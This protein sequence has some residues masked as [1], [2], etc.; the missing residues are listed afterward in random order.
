LKASVFP[1]SWPIARRLTVL[2]AL[3]LF[4]LLAVSAA[5]LDW[6][7]TTD[8]RRDN[9]QFLAAEM[10]NLRTLIRQRP[11]HVPALQ[12]EVEREAQSL[13]GHARFYAR[14]LN[15][16]GQI[17]V[18]TPGMGDVIE[19]KTFP[20]P[21]R[22]FDSRSVE[23]SDARGRDGRLFLLGAQWVELRQPGAGKRLIQVAFDRSHDEA[24]ISDYRKEIVVVLLVGFALSVGLGLAIARAGLKPI[25]SITRA[26]RRISADELNTRVSSREWPPE[27]AA[28]AAEFDAMLERLQNS[29][30]LLTQFSADLAHELRTPINNLRGEAEVAL[31]KTRNTEE[32]QSLLGSSLEEY[33]RLSRVIDNLLFLA[34]TDARHTAIRRTSVN[35]RK[36]ID[37]LLEYFE[38]LA[39]DKEID[40]SVTGNAL[41]NVDSALF[42]RVLVNLL[43]NAF[44]YTPQNGKIALSIHPVHGGI[45]VVVADTGIGIEK[46]HVRRVLDRFFRT[47]RARAIHPQGNGLGLPIVKSIMDLHSGHLSIE[48][49]P[50]TG[51]TVRLT[52][53]QA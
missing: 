7:L 8:M 1:P 18:E 3:S 35:V 15:E 4:L 44:Q 48:S 21:L 49:T 25:S 23:G 53:P 36:E 45:E 39:Q 13:P 34:R 11:A 43:S 50:G 10:Q 31:E 17:I 40:L 28:L 29:F 33:E 41:L 6:V 32:Y 47:E 9:S 16:Q 46:D 20:E 30:D 2:Y 14:I 22:P 26:F 27:V 52:F 19:S 5:F 51:T 12:E 37:P 38:P 42:R 24:I